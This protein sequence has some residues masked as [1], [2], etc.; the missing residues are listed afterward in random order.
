MGELVSDQFEEQVRQ[1]MSNLAA[2]IEEAG[3]S[4]EGYYS[5]WL[6]FNRSE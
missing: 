6:V 5:C 1:A 2:I 4:L 3:A